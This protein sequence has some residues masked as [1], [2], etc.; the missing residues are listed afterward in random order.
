MP[1]V[2]WSGMSGNGPRS[3]RT[4]AGPRADAG[5]TLTA[6]AP[7]RHAA[8]DLGRRGGPGQHRH[9]APDRPGQDLRVEMGR[10]EERRAGGHRSA[11][12]RHAQDRP[13]ADRERQARAGDV[14]GGRLERRDRRV[15]GLVEGQLEGADAAGHEG[16]GDGR[17]VGRDQPA[18]DGH[19]PA[20]GHGGRDGRPVGEHV[21]GHRLTLVDGRDA[22]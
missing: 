14:L 12:G 16:V 9:A 15:L 1:P 19:D 8:E 6:A 5:K 21:V 18:G 22:R 7:A 3:S 11:G 10:D 4:K 13:G 17:D 2:G 20:V